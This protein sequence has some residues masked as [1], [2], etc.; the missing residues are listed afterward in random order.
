MP[1]SFPTTVKTFTTKTNNV[2]TTDA[3]HMNDIQDEVNAIETL[4]GA[5]SARST[6]WTPVVRFAT[7][8]TPPT[9]SAVGRYA[10]FGSIVFILCRFDISALG[11]GTGNLDITGI[12][13]AAANFS[14]SQGSA[15]YSFACTFAFQTS[16][17]W[18]TRYPVVARLVPT[19]SVINLYGYSL[20]NGFE[21]IQNTHTTATSSI[22]FSGFYIHA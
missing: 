9:V 4:L 1:A 22:S 17:A 16:M 21:V 13:V 6:A 7:P 15:F 11:T 19:T 2:D 5:D 8:N 10:R 20:A 3:S 18:T 12:P 14:T